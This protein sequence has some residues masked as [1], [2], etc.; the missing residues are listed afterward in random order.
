MSSIALSHAAKHGNEEVAK[1][2]VESGAKVDADYLYRAQ[3]IHLAASGG[4]YL[5]IQFLI[6]NG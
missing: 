3:P 1:L 5:V 6:M 2:L 4:Y